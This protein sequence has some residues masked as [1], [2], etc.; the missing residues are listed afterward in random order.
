M[1][2]QARRGTEVADA[3]LIGRPTMTRLTH[4]P[5]TG[6]WVS[7]PILLAV[8]HQLHLTLLVLPPGA[9]PGTVWEQAETTPAC[10]CPD[11]HQI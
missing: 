2:A 8:G 9:D 3:A 4:S 10:R 11:G 6:Q 5:T 1:R 7:L